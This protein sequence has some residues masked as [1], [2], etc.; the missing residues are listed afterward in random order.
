MV[1]RPRMF[2]GKET[3]RV[4]SVE[5]TVGSPILCTRAW[6]GRARWSAE[7]TGWRGPRAWGAAGGAVEGRTERATGAD[8]GTGLGGRVTGGTV[9]GGGGAWARG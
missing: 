5:E 6:E 7:S 3:E 4:R 1:K 8:P 2:G 9:E